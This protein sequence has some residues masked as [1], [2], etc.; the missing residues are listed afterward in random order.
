[1]ALLA[2]CRTVRDAVND[3]VL[4][5]FLHDV[6]FQEIVPSVDVPGAEAF[7]REVLDRF[8]N[9]DVEHALWDITLQGTAKMRVRLVPTMIAYAERTGHAPRALAQAFAGYLAFQRGAVQEARRNADEAVP[10]DDEAAVVRAHWRMASDDDDALPR[11]VRKVCADRTLWNVDLTTIPRFVEI[12]AETLRRLRHESVGAVLTTSQAMAY[13]QWRQT[14]R[15]RARAD[16][17][18]RPRT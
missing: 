1:L 5:A 11:F 10:A 8:A 12:V 16:S 4:G 15:A 2:Q 6:L 3:P 9:P 7:A 13:D 17:S 14:L 18:L